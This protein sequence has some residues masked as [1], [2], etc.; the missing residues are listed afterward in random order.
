M[1]DSS[2]TDLC[3]IW[4]CV[5]VDTVTRRT[6]AAAHATTHPARNSTKRIHAAA[7]AHCPTCIVSGTWPTC[8]RSEHDPCFLRRISLQALQNKSVR[9]TK[10]EYINNK[11]YTLC[12]GQMFP[13]EENDDG[14]DGAAAA[15]SGWPS[16]VCWGFVRD[17]S[18]VHDTASVSNTQTH[19]HRRLFCND[20]AC[21]SI[22]TN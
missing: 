22:A 16:S 17:L 10:N 15:S 5:R 3:S 7:A 13:A 8:T 18:S 11:V 12:T 21:A 6:V 19:T 9:K 20:R 1:V 14:G 4:V 2:R